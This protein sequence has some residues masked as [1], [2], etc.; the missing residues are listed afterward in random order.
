MNQSFYESRTNEK[1]NNL[2]K[3][4]MMSQAYYRS[5]S[6]RAGFLSRLPKFIIVILGI[7]G[8]VQIFVR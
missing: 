7:L 2:R 5:R 8:L 3:Q 1:L 6:S 4:G